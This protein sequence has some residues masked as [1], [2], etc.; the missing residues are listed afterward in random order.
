MGRPRRL[1]LGAM[2]LAAALAGCFSSR[3]PL[4]NNDPEGE[5]RFGPSDQ[6]A[7]TTVVAIRG[8]V[9]D[10]GEVRVRTGGTVTWLNCEEPGTEAHTSTGDEGEWSSVGLAS[11]DVFAHT[12]SQPGTYSYHCV[13]HPF[14][15]GTVVVE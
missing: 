4:D 9:F 5:C 8:F 1:A 2:V 14:M 12:F 7:G 15:T 10:P 6:V 3:N 13:P 11:G